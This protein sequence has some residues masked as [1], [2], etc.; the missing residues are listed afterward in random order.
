LLS[1]TAAQRFDD[2]RYNK[3]VFIFYSNKLGWRKSAGITLIGSAVIL[4][5]LYLLGWL[6]W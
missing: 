5:G 3:R 6:P 1:F 4:G 2:Q